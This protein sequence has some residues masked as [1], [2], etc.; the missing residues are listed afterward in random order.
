MVRL[1]VFKIKYFFIYNSFIF[2]F[3]IPLTK[4]WKKKFFWESELVSQNQK[5]SVPGY[6]YRLLLLIFLGSLYIII[7]GFCWCIFV[8][9]K[10]YNHRVYG[11]QTRSR[12]QYTP[13]ARKHPYQIV[14]KYNNIIYQNCFRAVG[15]SILFYNGTLEWTLYIISRYTRTHV[16][17]NRCWK[18]V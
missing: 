13:V 16:D 9:T 5:V 17:E 6:V 10:I 11:Q 15:N 8:N 2:L 14:Y 4:K 3:S 18:I 1:S 12:L 7:N